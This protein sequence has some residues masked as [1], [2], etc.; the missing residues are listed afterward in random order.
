MCYSELFWPLLVVS[1]KI[2]VDFQEFPAPRST[3]LE[4]MANESAATWPQVSTVL[5][6]AA[7]RQIFLFQ[8][9]FSEFH[10]RGDIEDNSKIIFLIS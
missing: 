3:V 5:C 4:E 9:H 7:L 6:N 1:R 10:I 8:K 2:I